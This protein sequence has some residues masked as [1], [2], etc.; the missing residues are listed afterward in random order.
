MTFI[1][2]TNK[3]PAP[4]SETSPSTTTRTCRAFFRAAAASS[5]SLLLVS[6][7]K[8]A[9]IKR[10]DYLPQRE[11][12]KLR[13]LAMAVVYQSTRKAEEEAKAAAGRGARAACDG[14]RDGDGRWMAGGEA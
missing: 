3:S 10:K 5:A 12:Y 4:Y 9:N 6:R 13:A 1:F 11:Q 14:R 2:L 7:R 8:D